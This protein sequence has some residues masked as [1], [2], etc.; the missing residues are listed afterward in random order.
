MQIRYDKSCEDGIPNQPNKEADRNTN[1]QVSRY[2]QFFIYFMKNCKQGGFFFK[3][4]EPACSFIQ[5]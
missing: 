1:K 5:S 4:A 3:N 2:G